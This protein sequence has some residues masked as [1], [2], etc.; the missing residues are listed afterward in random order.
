M[1]AELEIEKCL[2]DN[3]TSWH[4]SAILTRMEFKNDDGTT[5]NPKSISRR[6]QEMQDDCII[7]VKYD[8]RK[9]TSSYRWIPPNWRHRYIP[10]HAQGVDGGWEKVPLRQGILV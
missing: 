10:S 5:A 1:S 3:K 8:G 4:P 9:R 6:L 7:A 2:R